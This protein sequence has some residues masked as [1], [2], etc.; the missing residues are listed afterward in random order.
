MS[1]KG[2]HDRV[3][4]SLT[5]EWISKPARPNVLGADTFQSFAHLPFLAWVAMATLR[6]RPPPPGSSTV[7]PPPPSSL[8][9]HLGRW[10]SRFSWSLSTLSLP[11]PV[12]LSFVLVQCFHF[13]FFKIFLQIQTRYVALSFFVWFNSNR[14]TCY[15]INT[16]NS[17]K[18]TQLCKFSSMQIRSYT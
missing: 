15:V 13:F 14:F 10:W 11:V 1:D 2:H 5:V 9:C 16:V 8:A 4:G 17:A 12:K 3:I 6:P 7:A 18:N